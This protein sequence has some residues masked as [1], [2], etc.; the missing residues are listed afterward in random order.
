MSRQP[1]VVSIVMNAV[2]GDSRVIKTAQAA[3]NAGY[4]ATIVGVA[5]SPDVVRQE[6]EGV[7]VVLLPHFATEMMKYGLWGGASARDLRLLV[8]GHLQALIPEIVSLEPDLLHSHDMIGLKL[9]AATAQAMTMSGRAVPWVHDVHEFVAGLTGEAANYMPTCL[10][11][12]R[13]YLHKADYLFTVS[14]PLADELESRYALVTRPTVTYNAPN[15]STFEESG[16]DIRSTLGLAP[17]DPLVAYVGRATRLRGCDTILDA[18]MK[19]DG[20][21]LCFVSQGSYVEGLKARAS[22]AGFGHRI[23]L[24][25]YVP[26][27]QVT[28]FVRTADVG[29]H[30]LVHYPNGEVAMPNKMFEYLHARLPIVVSDVAAM[31]QFVERN[32]IGATFVAQDVDSCTSAIKRALGDVERLRSNITDEL[33]EEYSWEAQERKIQN[34]YR[35]LLSAAKPV[36]PAARDSAA[37]A[38]RLDDIEFEARYGR[39]LAQINFKTGIRLNSILGP[40]F[41]ERVRFL[42]EKTSE[43]GILRTARFVGSRLVKAMRRG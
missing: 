7:P 21:H 11:Y 2:E 4:R 16:P 28:T 42:R 9:G 41:A 32:N 36:T 14:E 37:M 40:V 17:T 3:I 39:H 1:H 27:H 26:S 23:H 12:E 5:F 19:L 30:G 10:G 13:E 8:G 15:K 31:K 6:I 38:Q 22:K 25:P 34:V 20:V 24:L 43:E 35:G 33:I 29:I 18:V